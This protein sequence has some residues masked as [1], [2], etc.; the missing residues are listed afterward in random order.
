[1]SEANGQIGRCVRAE[2]KAE[3]GFERE[4]ER[5]RWEKAA[6]DSFGNRGMAADDS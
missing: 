5:L 1:M 4:R 2:P 3:P 6:R